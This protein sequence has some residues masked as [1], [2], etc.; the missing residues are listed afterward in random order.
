M[1]SV[2]QR[3]QLALVI[4]ARL[5]A[6]DSTVHVVY[7][8][9]DSTH[10]EFILARMGEHPSVGATYDTTGQIGV[11]LERDR[12]LLADPENCRAM[13]VD[14]SPGHYTD[15]MY[16]A[17]KWYA[18]RQQSLASAAIIAELLCMVADC[19]EEELHSMRTSYPFAFD[20]YGATV[21]REHEA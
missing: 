2:D 10:Y 20:P 15:P 1:L 8:P 18:G 12:L 5:N 14:C 4:R 9:G 13:T 11:Y 17:E 6:G 7:E 16:V 3:Q 19:S 21:G